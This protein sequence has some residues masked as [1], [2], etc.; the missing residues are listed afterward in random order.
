MA[1]IRAAL[2][3]SFAGVVEVLQELYNGESNSIWKIKW[4]MEALCPFK[5]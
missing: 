1:A 5:T 2:S 3:E 4:K